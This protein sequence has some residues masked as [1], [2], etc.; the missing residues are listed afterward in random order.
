MDTE[1][2]KVI[3][4]T[5]AS[6][7]KSHIHLSS[8]VWN[9]FT[10]REDGSAVCKY[11]SPEKTYGANT[12]NST[13]KG[14][15]QKHHPELV[16]DAK[17]AKIE[18]ALRTP[19][20]PTEAA[21]MDQLLRNF[22]I[23]GLQAFR[24]VE[25]PA[26]RDFVRALNCRYQAPCRQTVATSIAKEF[27]EVQE[28]I[29]ACF[30]RVPGLVTCTTDCW[31]SPAYDSYMAVTVHWISKDWE[32]RGLT[33]AMVDVPESHTG[34]YL[35]NKLL[36]ALQLYKVEPKVGAIISDNASNAM[37]ASSL[38][39][40]KL[41][42]EWGH[43][44]VTLRCVAHIIHLVVTAGLKSSDELLTRVKKLV[45]L[46]RK[47]HVLRDK[48]RNFCKAN[49]EAFHIPQ[50][51]VDI[52]W[53]STLTML[54]SVFTMPKSLEMTIEGGC[55][56]SAAEWGRLQ[57]LVDF[58]QV[59]KECTEV[60][61]GSQY[62]TMSKAAYMCN[63]L[64]RHLH[65]H[66]RIQGLDVDEMNSKLDKYLGDINSQA[67]LA[68]FL[69]PCFVDT[70]ERNQKLQAIS[71]LKN[72]LKKSTTKEPPR[73]RSFLSRGFDDTIVGEAEL[74]E[75]PELERYLQSFKLDWN[76]NPLE[77]WRKSEKDLP[78]LAA[79]ARSELSK[80]AS[81]VP[82]EQSFSRGGLIVT[83]LRNRLDPSTV[84]SLIVL[85]SWKRSQRKKENL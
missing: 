2:V 61:S 45:A 35:C 84:E 73:K 53:N 59:F 8:D 7:K 32:M 66:R 69:D 29:T 1:V 72:I 44:V 37:L 23:E 82:S 28:S 63:N 58:L 42:D 33:V 46:I 12:G 19:M 13:L 5:P 43:P 34:N 70:M 77:W 39:K 38:T 83:D 56:V 22:I 27:S 10:K 31:Q 24:M 6:P 20:T 30:K 15:L 57:E 79:I 11:C 76:G 40:E 74:E 52:R 51:E 80:L 49:G 14:H 9:H 26:F 41:S 55:G 54:E 4:P 25:S 68:T 48:L 62:V 60:V 64:K 50:A 17:Q 36:E 3:E 16:P 47:S 18:D 67:L 78:E 75:F 21:V 71:S 65:L 81:S 85:E